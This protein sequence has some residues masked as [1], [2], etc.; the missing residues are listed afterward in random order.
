MKVA[1]GQM[2]AT[3]DKAE[4]LARIRSMVEEAGAEGA[5]LVV[6]PEACMVWVE[7]GQSFAPQAEPLDGPFVTGLREVARQAE[8]ALVA[9]VVESIP[10]SSRAYNSVVAIDAGGALLGALYPAFKA[11]QK[12]PIDA[13]AY[14]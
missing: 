13:L 7:P 4:N 8:L 10:G 5:D 2:L 1:L 12:D 3:T 6:F 11:A 14:E 9:G